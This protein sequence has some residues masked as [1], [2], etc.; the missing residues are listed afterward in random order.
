MRR[1]ERDSVG[2]GYLMDGWVRGKGAQAFTLIE[3]LVVVGIIAVLISILL[4][5]LG[6]AKELANRVYCAANMR[7][8]TQSCY[9]YGQDNNDIYPTVPGPVTPNTW[10]CSFQPG[11]PTF[12][13]PDQV[14]A[15]LQSGTYVPGSPLACLWI[16]TM[17]KQ[18]PPKM[19]L[20]KSDRSVVTPAS[21]VDN[22][23]HFYPMVQDHYQFSYSIEYPWA[24]VGTSPNWRNHM[25]SDVPMMCD[26]APLSGDNKKDTTGAHGNGAANSENHDGKG[27]NVAYGDNH[28]E[29]QDKPYVSSSQDNMFTMGPVTSQQP[30]TSLGTLPMSVSASDFVMVPVRRTSDGDMGP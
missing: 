14:L 26:M 17:Q 2:L 24:G 1:G 20:C 18:A 29:F 4:P 16:L 21:M 15:Q 11:T 9:L 30:I 8:I 13:S 22:Q 7:G 6:K 10:R 28:V 12:T 3:L 27:Q 5:S 25:K 23:G 19:F